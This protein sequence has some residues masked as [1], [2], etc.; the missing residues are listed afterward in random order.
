MR[1]VDEYLLHRGAAGFKLEND[2]LRLRSFARHAALL[3]ERRVRSSTAVT[4]AALGPSR[5]ARHNRLHTVIRFI[6]YIRADAP[7]HELPSGDHFAGK[8]TRRTPHIFSRSEIGSLM[9]AAGQLGPAGS[10]RPATFKTFIGL[11]AATGLRTSEAR[12]LLLDDVLT[13]ERALVVRQSKFGKSRILPVHPS[14]LAALDAYI[15]QRRRAAPGG[16]HLFVTLT[17]AQLP[18]QTVIWTFA[19]LR[20]H[21]RATGSGTGHLP[22][23]L[24]LRHTFAVRALEASS[25]EGRDRVGRYVQAISQYLGHSNISHTYWY[26][27]ATPHL[28]KDMA[29]AAR[30]VVEKAGR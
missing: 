17:G 27:D 24:D 25:R 6:R 28:M 1:L 21:L 9:Q 7:E 3:G 8:Y 19:R 30:A 14:T 10:L 12:R 15:K 11:L 4:W 5:L 13:K 23:L 2:A 20:R 22:R 18:K 29:D 16:Q 26:F